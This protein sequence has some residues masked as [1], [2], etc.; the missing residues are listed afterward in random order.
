M[1]LRFL[2]LSDLHLGRQLSGL[3]DDTAAGLREAVREVVRSAFAT[4]R[5]QGVELV[6]MPGDLYEQDGEDPAAQLRFIYQQA[7]QVAP[8]PVVIAPG[9]HDAYSPDSP[10]ATE[11]R[12]ENVALFTSP[13]FT[14]IET[15][16]GT[17]VGRAYQAGEASG[18]LEWTSVPQPPPE[19]GLLVLHAS[20]LHAGDNRHHQRAIVPTALDNLLKSGYAYAALGHYHNFQPFQRQG[21]TRAAAAYAGCPQGLGWDEPGG[22]G[23]LLGTLEPDGAELKFVRAAR[24]EWKQRRL[25]LPPEY[26]DDRYERLDAALAELRDGIEPVDLLELKVSGAWPDAER[27]GLT[28]RLEELLGFAW[29][30]RALDLSAVSLVPELAPADSSDV[31]ADFLARCEAGVSASEDETEA[32]AWQ[33]ARRLGHRLLSGLELPGEVA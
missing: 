25:Q 10:Y 23:Y 32:Q 29:H 31:L 2:Q 1:A 13:H 20:L 24:H 9:N 19:P 6:L 17:V 5:E 30:S 15:R 33:L 3:P 12:P 27:S 14:A 7:A 8:V 26:M 16:A 18:A 11:Q 21:A 28:K 4:V 22:K